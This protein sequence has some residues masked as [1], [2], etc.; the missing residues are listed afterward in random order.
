MNPK[1]EIGL[2]IIG[3]GRIGSLRARLAAAHPSVRFIAVADADG[4]AADKLARTVGAQ[5]H[6]T[7]N[8]AAIGHPDVN[9]VI[10][11]TSENEHAAPVVAALLRQVPVLVEK[12]IALSVADADLMIRTVADLKGDLRVGYS[13]RF[14]TRYHLAK[15][16]IVQGRLGKITGACARLYNS[17][18]QCFAM[19]KRNKEAT[20]VVDALTYYVDL[21]GW[22][23][24][25]NPVVEVFAKGQKGVI[26]EAG[27]D[28]EDVTWAILT[29]RDGAVVNLGVSYALPEKWPSVGHSA[30]VELLGTHG[31]LLINDDHTDQVMQTD[32]GF[33]HVYLSGHGVETVF[34]ESSTPGDWAL[35]DFL[36]PIAD[37][38]R[39]WLDYLAMGK[40]CNLATPDDARRTL[41]VTLA[42]QESA[43]S[44]KTVQIAQAV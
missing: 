34:L 44:G 37:E 17:R 29:C 19:L 11:A 20:P 2:A 16:Q 1:K 36:G 3:S 5:F 10:V 28:T 14:K 35:G 31:V 18:S 33:P 21:M 38:T 7:D 32:V 23:L 12:P 22:L 13:R 27:Y 24:A 43:R 4:Q 41:A 25:D 26:A 42:I 9:A 6:T 8:R 30:R 40:P 15:E 39:A